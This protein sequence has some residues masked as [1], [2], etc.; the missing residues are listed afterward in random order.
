MSSAELINMWW[1]WRA[2]IGQNVAR[3]RAEKMPHNVGQ[4]LFWVPY[5]LR[6]VL[7]KLLEQTS[8]IG[9]VPLFSIILAAAI[10]L[11]K[12][13][14]INFV[15]GRRLRWIRLQTPFKFRRMATPPPSSNAFKFSIDNLLTPKS[16]PSSL[17]HHL[18][19]MSSFFN[20]KQSEED[21]SSIKFLSTQRRTSADEELSATELKL[22]KISESTEKQMKTRIPEED[23]NPLSASNQL[24]SIFFENAAQLMFNNANSIDSTNNQ[25]EQQVFSSFTKNPFLPLNLFDGSSQPG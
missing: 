6:I 19:F 3:L 11:L 7:S 16:T 1:L 8:L 5:H 13:V 25:I 22:S 4:L 9:S 21:S 2:L 24:P 14:L 12:V 17:A 23:N 20:S 18:A 15:V 10:P